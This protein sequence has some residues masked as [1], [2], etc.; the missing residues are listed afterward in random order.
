ME[1]NCNNLDIN[2]VKEIWKDIEDDDEQNSIST[3]QDTMK[4]TNPNDLLEFRP[5][6]FITLQTFIDKYW[7]LNSVLDH[8]YSCLQ[9]LKAELKGKNSIKDNGENLSLS[10]HYIEAS[11]VPDHI[12]ACDVKDEYLKFDF[13][14]NE[15]FE[16]IDKIVQ[17]LPDRFTT[18]S[19][20]VMEYKE[21]LGLYFLRNETIQK[22]KEFNKE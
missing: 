1:K 12:K 16:H 22:L 18:I 5:N 21:L 6:E 3:K 4:I 8:Q 11:D 14:E 17:I 2:E 15:Y 20:L 7:E 13:P 10:P 9:D 19:S